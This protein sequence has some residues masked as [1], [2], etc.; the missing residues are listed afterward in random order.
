MTSASLD[1]VPARRSDGIVR[2]AGDEVLIY[3]RKTN[4]AHCLNRTAAE[5]WK[6]CDGVRTCGEIVNALN[7]EF[8]PRADEDLVW[9]ALK[10]LDRARLFEKRLKLP[11]ERRSLSRRDLLHRMG[12]AAGGVLLLPVISSILVPTPAEAMS[13]IPCLSLCLLSGRPCCA[14]CTCQVQGLKLV[15]L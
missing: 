4:K 3:V 14:P 15:C 8:D 7:R 5:V 1:F 2:Q 11:V 10:Q 12:G 13:C 9:T 6:L